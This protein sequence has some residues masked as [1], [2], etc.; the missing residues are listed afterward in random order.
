MVDV[1]VGASNTITS[2]GFSTAEHVRRIRANQIGISIY[3]GGDLYP[4]PVPLSLINGQQL[5][6]LFREYL[7]KGKPDLP[8]DL[9]TRSEMLHILSISDVLKN[10][11]VDIADPRTLIIL[12]TL[13]GNM[14]LL[15]KDGH[16]AIEPD[17]VYLWKWGQFLGSFFNSFNTPL[18]VSNA[19]ASGSLAILI[20]ARLIKAGRYDH[21]IAAGGDILTEFAVSGFQSFQSLSPKPCKPFDAARDG[22]SL[23]EGCG[24]IV[25]SRNHSLCGI[26]EK[27][28]V[29]GG[30]CTNDA[31][32]ISGPLRTGEMFYVA[33][34]RAL[35]EASLDPL[36]IDYISAHGTG[37]DSNDETEAKALSRAGLEKVP[38]NSFKG[39][40][41]HTL[42]AAGIIESAL[43]I[44]SM[45]NNEL[46]RSA[47]FENPGTSDHINV[48]TD[49]IAREVNRC[50]KTAS[51]F[52][53]CNVAVVFKKI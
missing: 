51:G 15:K 14:D 24:A 17:R 23:G 53:G 39:Y 4:T 19:C 52:G 37:T 41:G 3:P 10:S 2:F 11:G 8:L 40:F 32:H 35:R 27:I 6:D 30:C 36:E 38:V 45:R 21:V 28:V 16:P 50:L 47:G 48:L 18:V 31:H 34:R 25:L 20:G 42:G 49:Y 13:K 29:A 43:A 33:I 5:L 12:S 46:F 26:P 7:R 22:L 9:F 1:F 44:A